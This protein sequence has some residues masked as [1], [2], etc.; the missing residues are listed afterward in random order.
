MNIDDDILQD[1]LIEAGE[2]FEQLGEQIVELEQQPEDSELLN[3][4]FRAFH[5]I[6]GG[7]GFL[8]ADA[9]VSI[10]HHAE[11]VF[12]VL[13]QGERIADAGLI[14]VILQVI[15]VVG[16]MFEQLREGE[17]LTPANPELLQQIEMLASG[18]PVEKLTGTEVAVDE[19]S[20]LAGSEKTQINADTD[21]PDKSQSGADQPVSSSMDDAFT[22]MLRETQ[23]PDTLSSNTPSSNTQ[24]TESIKKVKDDLI[25]DD[26]FEN[27]LDQLHGVGKHGG[28]PESPVAAEQKTQQE[29]PVVATQPATDIITDDEFEAV[30]DQMYGKN[31]GPGSVPQAEGNTVEEKNIA[32]KPAATSSNTPEKPEVKR[33]ASHPQAESSVRVDT[34]RLDD[35]MNLVGELVLV[36]NRLSTLKQIIKQ[37]QVIDAIANLELVTADLQASVMKTR[38]QP[39]KKVFNR[40][41][42][43]I[44][45][46]A[47]QLKKDVNLE[48][49]GEDTDLD[50]NLV[51]ALADPLIHLVRNAVDHGIE[52]PEERFTN[53]KPRQGRV[54]LCAAQE[55]DQILITVSDDGKGMDP[56]TLR[57]KAVEKELMTAED[58]ARLTETEV[59]NLIFAPGFST[60]TEISDVSGRGVGMDV[61]K[62][63]ITELNGSL[64][65][66]SKKGR[67]TIITIR[68][69][70]TLAI[71]PTLMVNLDDY[72]FAL[73]LTNVLEAFNMEPQAVNIV[74][75]QEVMQVRQRPL[76]LYYLYSWLIQDKVFNGPQTTQK[77]IVV[78][79]GSQ[80]FC[81]VVDGLIGQEE[82]VIKP[83]GAMIASTPG[84]AGATITGDGSIA[85]VLD[86]PSLIKRYASGY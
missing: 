22:A 20:I 11:D 52:S 46:L 19:D 70:L 44:R 74:D 13:R 79:M 33:K 1:F 67:G 31:G 54:I 45:D 6:K 30:L 55:G 65:I 37:E 3:A 38:M 83:L 81:L 62:T 35:I 56:D 53:G 40:F 42:R 66:N 71:L 41:P 85:L 51:E 82:V 80:R 78:Q 12:N 63:H 34:S 57:Q 28:I 27:L 18:E 23:T 64:E 48:L 26:E 15:D 7:A 2:L 47:R 25:T 60:K 4:I 43:V 9:M 77:V 14:D 58:A 86:I 32:E 68:L 17:P 8:K 72:Q 69:P 29:I 76:P 5:T 36:R 49:V 39:I 10:C 16:G 59:Y 61:V 21:Q 73:P 75:G 84:F 50:K 24:Q